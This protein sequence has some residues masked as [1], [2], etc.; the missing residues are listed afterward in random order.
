MVKTVYAEQN[1]ATS[2]ND[3]RPEVSLASPTNAKG[4]GFGGGASNSLGNLQLRENFQPI[5]YYA[6]SIITDA[7]GEATVKFKLPDDLTTWKI[8]AIA[9]AN[10][11]DNNNSFLFGKGENQLIAT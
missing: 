2:F 4:W 5:A 9:Y 6:G 3:N 11:P 1:I 10:S 8:Q 7:K